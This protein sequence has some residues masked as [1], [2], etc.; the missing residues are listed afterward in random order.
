MG[1]LTENYVAQELAAHG[2]NLFYWKNSNT[3]ELDF[4]LQRGEQIIPVEV[5][6]GNHVQAKSLNQYRITYHPSLSIRLSQKNF[7]Q[8]EDLKS[9][10]LYALFCL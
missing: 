8:E 10:P 5:K 2:N 6:K 4:L 7:G 1:A 3:A 9:V